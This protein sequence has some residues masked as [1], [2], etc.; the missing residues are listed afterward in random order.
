MTGD[1][2]LFLADERICA[3]PVEH[4]EEI[5]RPLPIEPIPETPP[6]VVGASIIRGRPAP[7]VDL[8]ALLSG[9][10]LETVSRLI[11]I[12]AGD[13]RRVGL[14]VTKVMGL[15]SK[16]AVRF[17]SIPPLLAGADPNIIATLGRLDQSLLSV[18]ELGTAVP[19]SVWNTIA[20]ERM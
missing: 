6:F 3:I 20:G 1:L 12:K 15:R 17:D 19:P 16:A 11:S 8:G 4:V 2:L 10:E 14:L 9:E 18:L 5:M 7:V 13:E